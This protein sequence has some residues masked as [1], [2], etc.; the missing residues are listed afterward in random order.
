MSEPLMTQGQVAQYVSDM[1]NVSYR[2][3]YDRWVH[4]LGFPTPILLPTMGAGKP[5]KRYVQAEIIEW[6]ESQRRAA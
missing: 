1:L 6:T 3:V 4:L 5:T 2:Q